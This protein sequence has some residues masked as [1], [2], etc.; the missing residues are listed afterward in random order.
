[1]EIEH[2]KGLFITNCPKFKK[3]IE[4]VRVP[5]GLEDEL[6]KYFGPDYRR[7]SYAIRSS[8]TDEDGMKHSFA[9]Q[10]E[11]YLNVEVDRI[12]E[13]IIKIWKSVASERVV[14]YRKE[15]GLP[16]TLGIAV[17]IQE[18]IEPDV[19]VCTAV[20]FNDGKIRTE[21]DESSTWET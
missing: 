17:I 3:E 16:P 14:K 6:I 19:A 7:K 20:T 18:M 8:A 10:F 2:L 9:G 21:R 11:T 1:M 4:Q 15:H 13:S 5:D 12:N